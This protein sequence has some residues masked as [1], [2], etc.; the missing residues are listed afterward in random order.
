MNIPRRAYLLSL[1]NNATMYK[2]PFFLLPDSEFQAGFLKGVV[3]LRYHC[4]MT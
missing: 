3:R 1:I 2:P 4:F